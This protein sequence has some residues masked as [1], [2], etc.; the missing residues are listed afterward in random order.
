MLFAHRALHAVDRGVR[1]LGRWYNQ[2]RGAATHA[3]RLVQRGAKFY[4][5]TQHLLPDGIRD[6]AAK[7]LSTYNQVRQKAIEG[8][9]A[10]QSLRP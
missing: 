9:R 7:G 4:N 5:A 2:A 6:K 10:I 3:D 1:R 8:D